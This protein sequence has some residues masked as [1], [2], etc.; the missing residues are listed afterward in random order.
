MIKLLKKA[1]PEPLQPYPV[2]YHVRIRAAGMLARFVEEMKRR[3]RV[4]ETFPNDRST[5][6][7]ATA[8]ALG[9][10][11]E[12]AIKRYLAINALEAVVKANPQLSRR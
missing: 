3:T 12:W 6:M 7:L 4:V 11:D 9:S 5:A 2:S 1:T 10:S 8:I